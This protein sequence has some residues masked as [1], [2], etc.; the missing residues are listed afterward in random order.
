MVLWRP[1][2]RKDSKTDDKNLSFIQVSL[3]IL[4]EVDGCL[5]STKIITPFLCS[6]SDR[7]NNSSIFQKH[8]SFF[9]M[10]LLL[11]CLAKQL[12]KWS[13]HHQQTN[14][15]RSDIMSK[16]TLLRILSC[17][18]G[19]FQ[20]ID[21]IMKSKH[22]TTSRIQP[23]YPDTDSIAFQGNGEHWSTWM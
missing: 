9:S 8:L 6:P 18:S 15:R 4:P 21:F 10:R 23:E 22:K 12:P 20:T 3:E 11:S 7:F 14:G 13:F 1:Q 5:F 19:A 2:T 16:I 17:F